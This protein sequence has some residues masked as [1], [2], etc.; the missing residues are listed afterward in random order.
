MKQWQ[1]IAITAGV[2]FIA[3]TFVALVTGQLDGILQAAIDWTFKDIFKFSSAPQ[4]F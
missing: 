2:I 1:K 3:M 4:L